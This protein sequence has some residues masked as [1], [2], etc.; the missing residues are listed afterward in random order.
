[1]AD[2]SVRSIAD[3]RAITTEELPVSHPLT[4]GL[5]RHPRIRQSANGLLP[6]VTAVL[7]LPAFTGPKAAG[8]GA[9]R[10]PEG[11]A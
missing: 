11:N 6:P 10:R 3:L 1:M 9:I 7:L 8:D 2:V 5:A 4:P